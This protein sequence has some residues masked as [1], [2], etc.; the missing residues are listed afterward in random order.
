MGYYGAPFTNAEI[1]AIKAKF[2]LKKVGLMHVGKI[3]E[4]PFSLRGVALEMFGRTFI[5]RLFPRF[6]QK[7]VKYYM[8]LA[9]AKAPNY[10]I[11]QGRAIKSD[12]VTKSK[13]FTIRVRCP[14]TD[15]DKITAMCVLAALEQI[16]DGTIKGNNPVA[17]AG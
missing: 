1:L 7:T 9:H 6:F 16:I 14:D 8:A 13:Q 2:G 5:G 10:T 17:M 11:M 3:E 12:K 15:A 4:P